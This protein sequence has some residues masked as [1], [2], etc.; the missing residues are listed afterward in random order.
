MFVIHGEFP[1]YANEMT[2]VAAK[3]SRKTNHVIR[4]LRLCSDVRFPGRAGGL[5]VELNHRVS[6][7]SMPM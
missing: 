2:Q 1:S 7:S 3:H 6:Q 5:G 4:G